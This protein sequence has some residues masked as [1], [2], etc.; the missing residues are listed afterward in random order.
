MVGHSIHCLAFTGSSDGKLALRLVLCVIPSG[1]SGE[2][3]RIYVL[4]HFLHGLTEKLRGTLHGIQSG[5]PPG[6]ESPDGNLPTTC[7]FDARVARAKSG[8][9][10]QL[11]VPGTDMN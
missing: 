6:N 3:P 11:I 10:Q 5:I 1:Y 4:C 7:A 2:S 9:E 8:R